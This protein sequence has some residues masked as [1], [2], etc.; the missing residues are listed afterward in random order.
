MRKLAPVRTV[1]PADLPVTLEDMKSYCVVM[2]DDDD[3]VLMAMQAA[4]VSH[5][6]GW[7]GILG[8][9][10]VTQTWAQ[11]FTGFC[12]PMRLPLGPVASIDSIVYFDTAGDQQT[13]SSDVYVLRADALGGYVDLKVGQAWPATQ[14]RPDAVTVT[15]VAGSAPADVP[16]A[17][18][19]AISM[20]V[21]HW[22]RHREA[23]AEGSVAKIPFGVDA[24]L[25]PHK[26]WNI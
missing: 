25:A 19:A 26:R 2:H 20:L 3:A 1:A 4:A 24:M 15:F 21:A 9:C 12:T 17:I 7:S 18:K 11:D 10:I 22:Y 14:G 13:L 5:L 16:A 23:V 6:D 8:R